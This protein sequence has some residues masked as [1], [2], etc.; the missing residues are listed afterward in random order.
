LDIGTSSTSAFSGMTVAIIVAC[1]DVAAV[2]A[3][4]GGVSLE[5]VSRTGEGT[6]EPGSEP[7]APSALGGRMSSEGS[8]ER[9]EL[10]LLVNCGRCTYSMPPPPLEVA[11]PSETGRL[12]LRALKRL[13]TRLSS[14]DE[15]ETDALLATEGEARCGDAGADTDARGLEGD[16]R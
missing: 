11:T 14:L 7:N 15:D 10:A 13:E 12:L 3:V 6:G 2:D 9:V 4:G 16:A 1:S 8:E 5:N